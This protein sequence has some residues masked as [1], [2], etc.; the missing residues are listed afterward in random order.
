MYRLDVSLL[1]SY[2]P[3]SLPPSPPPLTGPTQLITTEALEHML[4][5]E[6]SSETFATI[7]STSFNPRGC[8]EVEREGGE[9]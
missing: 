9:I 3:P 7:T 6:A 2:L 1:K 4:S 5:S 8:V